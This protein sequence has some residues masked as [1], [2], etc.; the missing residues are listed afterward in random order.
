MNAKSVERGML[1]TSIEVV[2]AAEV[3]I[4]KILSWIHLKIKNDT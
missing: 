1:E 4:F 2:E 3:R